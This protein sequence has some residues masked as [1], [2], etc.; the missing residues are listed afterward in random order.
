MSERPTN[1]D[2]AFTALGAHTKYDA[3]ARCTF[4]PIP[5]IQWASSNHECAQC[6]CQLLWQKARL[7]MMGDGHCHRLWRRVS[8]KDNVWMQTGRVVCPDYGVWC[9][10]GPRDTVWLWQK[11]HV[12]ARALQ[13][14]NFN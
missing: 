3:H 7:V 5:R 10:A 12:C 9:L 14:K 4:R 2:I 13:Q 8:K 6:A 11:K 1:I